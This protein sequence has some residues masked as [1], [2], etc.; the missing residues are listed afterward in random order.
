MP[1][2]GQLPPAERIVALQGSGLSPSPSPATSRHLPRKD[3][4]GAGYLPHR[5][6]DKSAQMAKAA[7]ILKEKGF[8]PQELVDVEVQWFYGLVC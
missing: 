4:G 5:F 8:I 3:S 7:A 1:T 2:L 6:A